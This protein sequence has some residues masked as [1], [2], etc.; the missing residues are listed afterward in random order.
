MIKKA[1]SRDKS[2]LGWGIKL[3]RAFVLFASRRGTLQPSTA[4]ELQKE[5]DSLVLENQMDGSQEALSKE[6]N[7]LIASVNIQMK[8]SSQA[9]L[10]APFPQ[11]SFVVEATARSAVLD[12]LDMVERTLTEAAHAGLLNWDEEGRYFVEILKMFSLVEQGKTHPSDALTA[13]TGA[14]E[15]INKSLPAEFHLPSLDLTAYEVYV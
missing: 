2:Q 14:I 13:L 5:I 7:Q 9:T 10:Y 8:A 4:I 15:K 12:Q 6:L 3:L 11:F 1:K